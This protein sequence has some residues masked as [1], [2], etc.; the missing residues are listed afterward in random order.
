MTISSLINEGI[1]REGCSRTVLRAG[2]GDHGG[3]VLALSVVFSSSG[4]LS[5]LVEERS[6]SSTTL[7]WRFQGGQRA[8]IGE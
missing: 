2:T 6:S 4:L 5:W 7:G 3:A 1:R 8:R